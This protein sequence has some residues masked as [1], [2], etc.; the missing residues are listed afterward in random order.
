MRSAHP[1]V[2][3]EVATVTEALGWAEKV[4]AAEQAAATRR[5][6]QAGRGRELGESRIPSVRDLIPPQPFWW[7]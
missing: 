3:L 4:E 7:C 1:L 5:V 6:T 2:E